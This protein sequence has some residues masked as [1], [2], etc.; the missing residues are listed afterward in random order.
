[1][2]NLHQETLATHA[3]YNSQKEQNGAVAVP[4]Y[5]SNAFDFGT[6][7]T[8]AARFALQELGPI[9]SRLTNPTV[10]VFEARVG[11][12]GGGK[13][14]LTPIGIQLIKS[15]EALEKKLNQCVEDELLDIKKLTETP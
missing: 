1:M 8:A 14:E 3:G 7:Q 13:T 11:G 10:D 2:Q 9:Y 5:L 15:Y 12:K 6:S 4:L